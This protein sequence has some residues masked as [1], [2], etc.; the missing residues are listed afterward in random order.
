MQEALFFI[1]RV[2]QKSEMLVGKVVV[3]V[4]KVIGKGLSQAHYLS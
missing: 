1:K 2:M 4:D 3:L